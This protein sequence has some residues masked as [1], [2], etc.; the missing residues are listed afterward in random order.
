[1]LPGQYLA[2]G[3]LIIG[4][5]MFYMLWR[6]IHFMSNNLHVLIE[7]HEEINHKTNASV[8][9]TSDD[10]HMDVGTCV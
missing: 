7:E 10:S 5:G 6:Q 4:F 2:I 1:M 3:V 8:N 9:T